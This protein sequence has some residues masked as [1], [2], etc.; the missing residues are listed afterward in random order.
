MSTEPV[1]GSMQ[2]RRSFL[3]G[4]AAATAATAVAGAASIDTA[5]A[6]VDLM[7][8]LSEGITYTR[9]TCSPN[10]TGACGMV[11]AVKDGKICTMIQAADYP[12]TEYNPRGCLKG[13]TRNTE[14]Y[15]D[16]RLTYPMVRDG[17]F[18]DGAP[19]RRATW[20][21]ALD[22]CVEMINE[23]TDKYG[24]ESVGMD[25]QV[26]PLNYINKGTVIRL[27]NRM[28]W[29]NFPGYEMNGDLPIFYPETFGCQ[30]EELE[31]YQWVDS[32]L[33][34]VYGSNI[35]TTRMPD[36]H[37]IT[38][39]QEQGGKLIYLDH[40]YSI[41]AAKA[42]EWI[43]NAPGTDVVFALAMAK[44]I[45][46]D[47]A[48]D[49]HFM[50][51]YTDS[52]LLVNPETMMRVRASE[53]EGLEVP[54]DF[55]AKR[56]AFVIIRNGMPEIPPMDMLSDLD[57]AE[58]EGEFELA[59]KDGSTI[60][61]KPVFQMIK[62]HLATYTS[63]YCADTCKIPEETIIRVAKMA[64]TI[65]PMHIAQGGSA[66]QWHHGDLKGRA[67]ALVAALTGNI[68][69]QGGGI[70]CY[71]GQYKVRFKPAAWF[72][73]S[74]NNGRFLD[75]HYFMEG[76]TETMVSKY[77]QNGI[78]MLITGWANP[79]DQHD[80]DG[81]LKEQRLDGT[82]EYQITCDFLHTTTVDYADV[83]LP[84]CAWYE[85]TDVCT[86]P[87]HPFI[88]LQQKAAEPAGESRAEIWIFTELAH[89]LGVGDEFPD[90][91]DPSESEAEI[92][93]VLRR[94][95]ET[96]GDSVAGIT[97]EQLR[98]G[99]VK[100]NHY[101]NNAEGEKRIPFYPHIHDRKL[102]PGESLPQAPGSLDHLVK[103][104]RME[105][106]K[107]DPMFVRQ[108]EQ[109][110]L[111]KPLFEDTEYALDPT[112]REK[113]PFIY[114]TRNS[115]YRIHSNYSSNP[116]MLEL[117]DNMPHVW[118]HPDDMAKKG[119]AEG[120]HVTVYNNHGE[121]DGKLVPEPGLYPGQVIFEMGWWARYTHMNSYNSLIYPFINPVHE[122]Y[123]IASV[124]DP[125]LAFN[126][127]VCDVKLYEE[128]M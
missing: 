83:V 69:T 98:Q 55:P 39:M 27:T 35:F 115:I 49:A 82:I 31:S 13:T 47:G 36:A 111:Y 42:N 24:V 93:K 108:G 30:T 46:D 28:G 29:T 88:Q 38:R 74:Q 122:Q 51:T 118:M 78:R 17:K 94:V 9:S 91:F 11:A 18:L 124:W 61:A 123:A 64:E 20:D 26:P 101:H 95:L 14:L 86:T 66:Q 110:P 68:G 1:L 62:E 75:W 8:G 65:K 10:C 100:M 102:F 97:V 92:E 60:K 80:F 40:N 15:G 53:V 32:K 87:L 128:A 23:I 116:I 90:R 16:D 113:Y 21:E 33:M 84:G 81:R 89:R 120:D 114:L 54:E 103:S 117:Q 121:V 125:V 34:I 63:K 43:Q 12:E 105:I 6:D 77:P 99:P 67:F 37:L 52:P 2:S 85:K 126:E 44:I 79:Y 71:I 96:G 5:I 57:D 4:A 58:L 112:A 104:G 109:L 7:S 119:F 76:P 70:S 25:Y 72:I 48:Y 127:C 106:F 19:L 73:P 59:L 22:K 56:E 41:T 3:K 45:I 107:D 50:K